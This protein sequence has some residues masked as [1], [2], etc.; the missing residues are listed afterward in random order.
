MLMLLPLLCLRGTD[1]GRADEPP[2]EG[3][4]DCLFLECSAFFDPAY[5]R[6]CKEERERIEND[7]LFHETFYYDVGGHF[8]TPYLVALAAG[9][10][11]VEARELSYWAQYPDLDSRYD[12]I[13]G[14]ISW[15]FGYGIQRYLH[16]LRGGPARVARDELSSYLARSG[17]PVWKAGLAVHALGDS[18]AHS[19][20]PSSGTPGD[21]VDEHLYRWPFGHA[22]DGH[23][24]DRIATNKAKFVRYVESLFTSLRTRARKPE[25]RCLVTTM[26]A[27]VACDQWKADTDEVEALNCFGR[28]EHVL[29][30]GHPKLEQRLTRAQVREWMEEISHGSKA[31]STPN[32]P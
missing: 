32:A 28:Q 23:K 15:D 1:V 10:D 7:K 2:S 9:V 29:G 26:V 30:L 17:L 11:G 4:G 31:S 16:S 25:R 5:L 27:L 13:R 12:A 3:E 18:F 24:P 21:S 14:L 6:L 19:Y 8:T 20:A 22:F